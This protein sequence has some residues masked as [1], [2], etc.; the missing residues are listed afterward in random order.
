[1]QSSKQGMWKGYLFREKWYIKGLGVGPLG[2]ATS[3]KNLLSTLPGMDG[4]LKSLIFKIFDNQRCR[5]TLSA[6]IQSLT[7][8]SLHCSCRFVL[9]VKETLL[10]RMIIGTPV[11]A[12]SNQELPFIYV[13]KRQNGGR[14]SQKALRAPFPH[15]WS[16]SWFCGEETGHFRSSGEHI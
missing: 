16:W 4:E 14:N 9:N 8:S 5:F 15:Q 3:Y 1:M 10:T 7:E 6:V 13:V 2:E 11:R 12:T